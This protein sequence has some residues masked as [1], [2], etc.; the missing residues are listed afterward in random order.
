VTGGYLAWQVRHRVI[1]PI[2]AF[3]ENVFREVVPQFS[4]LDHRANQV[5]NEYYERAVFVADGSPNR[6]YSPCWDLR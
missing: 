5:G 6:L 2:L 4:S 1:G 3:G